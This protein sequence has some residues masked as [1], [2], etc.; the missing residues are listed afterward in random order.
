MNRLLRAFRFA[1]AG[2]RHAFVTQANFRIHAAISAIVIIAALAFNVGALEWAALLITIG[3][4]LQAELFNTALEAIVDKA[5]P[6]KHPLAMVAK[7]CAAGAVFVC[8]LAAVGVG[9][10]VFG[11]R[12]LLLLR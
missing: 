3:L 4:V 12:L 8:A 11:P 10:A 1:V 5:S 6:E 2:L 9:L 7:D